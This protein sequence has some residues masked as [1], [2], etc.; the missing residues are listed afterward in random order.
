MYGPK[1]LQD[2]VLGGHKHTEFGKRVEGVYRPKSL[3]DE[4]VVWVQT[5]LGKGLKA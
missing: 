1:R 4:G 2:E 3:L 5:H